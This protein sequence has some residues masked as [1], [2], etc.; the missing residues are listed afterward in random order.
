MNK[1]TVNNVLNDLSSYEVT[2]TPYL[3][4]VYCSITGHVFDFINNLKSKEKFINSI[5]QQAYLYEMKI[6]KTNDELSNFSLTIEEEYDDYTSVYSWT[7]CTSFNGK[8]K[9]QVFDNE[10]D[11]TEE[12]DHIKR[13]LAF[14]YE[15]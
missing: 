9:K 7:V 5:A 3:D 12:Y 14:L 11:A 4:D 15:D 8:V 1:A 10:E 2:K 13:K 6:N